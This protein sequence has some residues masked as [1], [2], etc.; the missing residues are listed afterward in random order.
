MDLCYPEKRFQNL[1]KITKRCQPCRARLVCAL[2]FHDRCFSWTCAV[3]RKQTL[4]TANLQPLRYIIAWY[5]FLN[6]AKS[7]LFRVIFWVP[8]GCYHR[9]AYWDAGNCW[10]KPEMSQNSRFF[11]ADLSVSPLLKSVAALTDLSLRQT[12]W[13]LTRLLRIKAFFARID[14]WFAFLGLKDFIQSWLFNS[15]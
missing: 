15:R 3:L 6:Y 14:M 5:P 2:Y 9:P 1:A 8:V 12:V 13:S 11:W 7:T 10:T 4:Y